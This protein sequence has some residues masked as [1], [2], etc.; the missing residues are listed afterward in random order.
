M[1]L[2]WNKCE[3]DQWCSL[4]NVNLNHLHFKN[5]VGVYIIW[6]SGQQPATVYVGKGIIAERLAQHRQ[7]DAILK[8]SHLGLFV[9]WAQVDSRSQGGVER[10]LADRLKPK[11]GQHHSSDSPITVNFPW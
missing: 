1:N 5:L 4:M 10:F 2:N 8:F 9:T 11:V 6:H 7:D 3:G